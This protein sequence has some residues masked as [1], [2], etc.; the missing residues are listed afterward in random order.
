M[1]PVTR[2]NGQAMIISSASQQS[3]N[4]GL[5]AMICSVKVPDCLS[6]EAMIEV[7]MRRTDD[8]RTLFSLVEG[9]LKF[10][11]WSCDFSF[12]RFLFIFEFMLA[13]VGKI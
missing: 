9:S 11:T 4:N 13:R 10:T 8:E 12:V 2:D 5:F 7:T 6:K 1:R 3:P